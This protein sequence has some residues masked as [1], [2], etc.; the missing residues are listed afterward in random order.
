MDSQY[1][2]I[3]I[4]GGIAGLTSALYCEDRI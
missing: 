3:I 4:G 2:V 1:D